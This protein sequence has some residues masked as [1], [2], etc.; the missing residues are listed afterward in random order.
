MSSL[1]QWAF[2]SAIPSFG[3]RAIGFDDMLRYIRTP[4]K[5]AIIH[6]M[7]A[8]ESVVIKGTLSAAEEESFINEYLSKYTDTQ[9]NCCVNL[10]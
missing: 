2:T 7:P 1:L 5:Y 10:H 9:K 4:S 8:T 3:D 6:T